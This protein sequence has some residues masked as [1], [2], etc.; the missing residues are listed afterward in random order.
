MV[1]DCKFPVEFLDDALRDQFVSELY[2]EAI[3]FHLLSEAE[4]TF[5]RAMTIAQGMAAAK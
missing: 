3:Q 1:I 4:L 5:A 2:N